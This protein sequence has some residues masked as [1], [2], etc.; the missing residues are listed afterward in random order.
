MRK[1][2]YFLTATLIVGVEL[3]G[4]S[5]AL[6]QSCLQLAQFTGYVNVKCFGA[7]G[8]GVADDTTAIQAAIDAAP[9]GATVGLPTGT[10][11]VTAT[12]RI[13]KPLTLRGFGIYV[14]NG[15]N[16]YFGGTAWNTVGHV[17]GSILKSTVASGDAVFV[18]ETSSDSEIAGT[19]A[20]HL[21]DLGIIGSGAG[22]AVGVRFGNAASTPPISSI[23][24]HW[25]NVVIGN[26]STGL[27]VSA[28]NQCNFV[29]LRLTGDRTGLVS[30]SPNT[31]ANTFI[32]L[33]VANFTAAIDFAAGANGNSFY[34]GLIQG[35]AFLDPLEP[36]AIKI[37]G[38]NNLISGF[39]MENTQ[40]LG[41]DVHLTNA[42]NN[43]IFGN[44]D[45]KKGIRVTGD[46]AGNRI[47]NNS[48]SGLPGPTITI[49]TGVRNTIVRD[50]NA[51]PL[52]DSGLSTSGLDVKSGI[53]AGGTATLA[54]DSGNVGIGTT[55]PAVKLHVIGDFIATGVKSAVVETASYGER[56]LYAMESPENWFEDFGNGKLIN[57]EAVVRLDPIFY[58]TINTQNG[59]HVFL[60]PKGDCN[61]LFVTNQTLTSF[62]VRELKTGRATVAFDYRVIAN[63]RGYEKVRLGEVRDG[64]KAYPKRTG[65]A[66]NSK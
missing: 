65:V 61:G 12:L 53:H 3:L 34:G 45:L 42:S 7:K 11:K 49:D 48:G 17:S 50:N 39:W 18:G 47:I 22:N 63:R 10:Y 54:T 27:I 26:F 14:F 66:D 29:S 6:A 44:V 15:S 59:Y 33:E 41:Y 37:S 55:T 21:Y 35:Q 56:R 5:V 8:D 52:L 19:G 38:G 36:D 60:T 46:S 20:F 64:E 13:N 16:M 43:I 58:E 57:G 62:E 28:V 32:G 1:S 2:L 25:Q 30:D 23:R 24:S 4:S 31:I 9:R 40:S 51:L